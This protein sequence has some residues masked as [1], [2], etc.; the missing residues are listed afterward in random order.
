VTVACSRVV[1]RVELPGHE[2]VGIRASNPGPFTLSG[3]NSWLMG[4]D[5]AW[6]VDPGPTL[7]EHLN[8]L[9]AEIDRRGGLGGIA[10]THDHADH[11]EAVREI[12]S[13]FPEARLAAARGDV[14]RVLGEGDQ[15]GP[16][17]AVRT[18]GHAPDH[19]AFVAGDVGFTGD[20][21][22]GEGSVFIFPD[23]GALAGYLE[24]L[25]RLRR[26]GLSILAPGHGPPVPD[27]QSKLAEY[28]SHRLDRERRL[29]AALD[30]GK[31]SIDELLDEVWDDAPVALR[32]AAAVT[33]AAHLDK[34]DDEGRLPDGVERP[35]LKL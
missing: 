4:H 5:P 17:V 1:T 31:R 3:T 34:L 7:P 15:F 6:L 11:R 8:A 32:R 33:L 26:R 24:G 30:A 18:P 27:A 25:E 19:L 29:V 22:L 9:Q 28:V 14:D 13:R 23:P 12:R 16:L 10:L 35:A 21:V 2:I 20:A